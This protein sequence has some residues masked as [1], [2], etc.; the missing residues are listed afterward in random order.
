MDTS[1]TILLIARPVPVS[2]LWFVA[3]LSPCSLSWTWKTMEV[4]SSYTVLPYSALQLVL[5]L[6]YSLC[7]F[8][9]CSKRSNLL[10]SP[11]NIKAPLVEPRID[12]H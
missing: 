10:P 11:E 5:A 12:P 9:P 2:G 1:L 7:L 4:L 3:T 8:L 6:A